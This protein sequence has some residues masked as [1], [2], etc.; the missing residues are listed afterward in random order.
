MILLVFSVF[1]NYRKMQ[2]QRKCKTET[3]LKFDKDEVE[4][5]KEEE[6]E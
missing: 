3:G 6:E 2:L 5:K 1:D 4:E